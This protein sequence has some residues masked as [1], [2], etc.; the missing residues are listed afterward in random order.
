MVQ[1]QPTIDEIKDNFLNFIKNSIWVEHSSNWFDFNF[2]IKSFDFKGKILRI[3]TFQMA[4]KLL[5]L[6]KYDLSNVVKKLEINFSYNRDKHKALEDATLTAEV[7]IKLCSILP[8][9]TINYMKKEGFLD[10]YKS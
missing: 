2:F 4:K 8:Q 5:N 10:E 3:S 1:G 9:Q 6:K 7:F